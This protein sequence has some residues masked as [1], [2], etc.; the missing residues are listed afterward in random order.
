MS[1]H[2]VFLSYAW[3]AESPDG[4]HPLASRARS[5]ARSLR[6]SG[7]TVWLDT[8]HMASAAGS[9][10]DTG[11]GI[12]DAMAAAILGSAAVV[13]CVSA[14][15]AAS[16]NCKTEAQFARKR[17]KAIF[18]VNV[19]EAQRAGAQRAGERASAGACHHLDAYHKM[20]VR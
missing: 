6:S 9:A 5:V 2:D 16:T 1:R 20:G 7:L 14:A 17:G 11:G 15:Y 8:E 18:Y 19:G 10:G 12:D 4:S 13:A 3:G